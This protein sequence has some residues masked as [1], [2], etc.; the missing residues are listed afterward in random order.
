M[1]GHT[2][3][4]VRGGTWGVRSLGAKGHGTPPQL[5]KLRPPTLHPGPSHTPSATSHRTLRPFLEFFLEFFWN[6]LEFFGIFWTFL[7]AR[8][9]R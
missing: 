1:F 2:G 4:G 8:D 3:D 6:F 9:H 7:E 5:L